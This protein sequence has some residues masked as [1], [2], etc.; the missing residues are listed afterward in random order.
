M[1]FT[2]LNN[3]VS[4][5][6]NHLPYNNSLTLV[7]A[8]LCWFGTVYAFSVP[9]YHLIFDKNKEDKIRAVKILGLL[10]AMFFI[11]R[12]F[13]KKLL[14]HILNFN[15]VS[16]YGHWSLI[17]TSNSLINVE[18]H[19]PYPSFPSGH[20]MLAVGLGRLLYDFYN[21]LNTKLLIIVCVF[22]CAFIKLYMGMHTVFDLAVTCILVLIV[23]EVLSRLIKRCMNG[24]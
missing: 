16:S 15:T 24:N 23:Y 17:N 12:F 11:I 19:N 18:F 6:F 21:S 8:L 22:M 2:W 5:F 7:L 13:E 4:L 9:L 20:V 10:V 14:D 3:Q 1:F